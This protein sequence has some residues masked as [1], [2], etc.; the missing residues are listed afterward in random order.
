MN[1]RK[2]AIG[3]DWLDKWGG[4][5]RV[6]LTLYEMFPNAQ[7]YTSYFDKDKAPWAKQLNP[8]TSFIQKLPQFIRGSRM[9][10]LPLYP[11]AFESFDFSG[12]DLVISVTSSFAKGVITRPP[13]KHICYLLTPTRFLWSH[14]KDYGTDSLL[15]RPY[16]NYLKRWDKIAS[17]RPDHYVC[18]SKTVRKRLQ[19]CYDR[20]GVVIYPPFDVEYWNKIKSQIPNS[21]FQLI[22][23]YQL[24]TTN[25]YLVVSRL[26]P[27]KRVDLVIDVFNK[28]GKPLV[29]VGSGS[30]Y[31]KLH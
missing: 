6:L 2:I 19:L 31:Q 1:Y 3:D 12:Y 13:T 14:Q 21:K 25:Y 26:E 23:E 20:A 27:Y 11:F 28:I 15:I 16:I 7:W 10:S 5:E 8:Q 17:Q 29:I 18:I 9:A 30:Q 24:P 22:P 4:V